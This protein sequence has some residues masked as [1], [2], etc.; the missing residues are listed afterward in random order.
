MPIGREDRRALLRKPVTAQSS[1]S[2][3]SLKALSMK[4]SRVAGEEKL[5]EN[6][7][8]AVHV[9]AI[10]SRRGTRL[11]P[12]RAGPSHMDGAL[13]QKLPR[14][15]EPLPPGLDGRPST[16]SPTIR[17]LPLNPPPT[18]HLRAQFPPSTYTTLHPAFISQRA[19]MYLT[20]P[21][22]GGEGGG[23]GGEG[24][25]LGDWWWWW[26]WRRWWWGW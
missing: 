14:T 6:S 9:S 1:R 3:S 15:G 25:G 23:E 4:P 17:P 16:Y 7:D 10:L 24:R 5:P 8:R 21:L 2:Y 11:E 19:E 20:N 12:A 22:G 18:R 13:E 26:W